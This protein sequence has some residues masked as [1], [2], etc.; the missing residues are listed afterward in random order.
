M[1]FY[2]CH[3]FPEAKGFSF[4]RL[5]CSA[6]FTWNL[7][8]QQLTIKQLYYKSQKSMQLLIDFNS[9]KLCYVWFEFWVLFKN[10]AEAVFLYKRSVRGPVQ[11]LQFNNYTA[12][13]R[14]FMNYAQ[15]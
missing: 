10:L 7:T 4:N 3:N 6:Q 11:Y 5:C 8:K 13:G 12:H 15:A 1:Y 14:R 9:T 2:T